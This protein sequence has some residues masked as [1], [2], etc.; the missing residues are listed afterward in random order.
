MAC[1]NLVVW[2]KVLAKANVYSEAQ[3]M[4]MQLMDDAME[5][6]KT[7]AG[8]E[9]EVTVPTVPGVRVID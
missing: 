1:Y 9:V 2:Q 3:Q 6:E 7:T 5:Y 4:L 8:V